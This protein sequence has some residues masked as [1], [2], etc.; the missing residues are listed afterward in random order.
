MVKYCS[1]GGQKAHRSQHKME[2]RIRAAELHDEKLFKDPSQ[3]G[4]DCPI[5][6]LL[7]PTL[8]SGRRYKVCCGKEICSGC[9]HAPVYDNNGNKVKKKCP[10]C[11][12]PA[13]TSDEVYKKMVMDRVE[14]GGVHA[15]DQLGCWYA[16]GMRGLPQDWDKA[17]ELW[18]QAGELGYTKAYC[19]IGLCYRNGSGVERDEKKATYYW[20]LAAIGGNTTARHNLGILE[21]RAEN[22]NRALKHFMISVEGGDHDCVKNIKQMYSKGYATRDDYAKALRAYQAYLEEVK[23]NDRDKLMCFFPAWRGL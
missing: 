1:R 15:M 2:C 12:A 20:E 18:H 6:F 9:I 10:F 22:Y 4:E 3:K 21:C 5:C 19:N 23:S 17:L 8:K 14:V 16:E 7:L 13:A 11:R